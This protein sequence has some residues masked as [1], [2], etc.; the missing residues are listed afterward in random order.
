VINI[1]SHE[2]PYYAVLANLLSLGPRY[3]PQHPI[4][5]HTQSMFLTSNIIPR[6]NIPVL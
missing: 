5:K 6:A 3:F 2:F 1:T 4:L